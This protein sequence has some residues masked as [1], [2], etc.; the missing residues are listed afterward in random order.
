MEKK[1]VIGIDFGT[2]SGRA[3][4]VDT[5]S[6]DEVG[7]AVF[8]Y[9]H[10]V[11]DRTLPCGRVLP[12][13]F[14]LE[15]PRD[16]LETL[17]NVIPMALKD[18]GVSADEVAAL[19]IDFTACTLLPV[20]EDGTPLC[21]AEKYKSEPHAYVK[22]WKHHASQPE[23]DEIT[24]LAKERGESFLRRYGGKISSE[25]AFPKIL[26][27]LR[28]AP[29]VY[30]DTYRFME[31]ADWLSLVLT[32]VETHSATFAGCKAMWDPH[33]GYPS[34]DFFGALDERMRNIIGTKVSDK[35]AP[36]A[37][38]A[39][40]VTEK[41]S[42]IC[43][44]PVGTALAVPLPD[45]HIAM[46]ALGI[47]TPGEL[48]VILGTSSCQMIHSAEVSDIPGICGYVS[49]SI[50]P[51]YYTYEAGQSC[52]GDTFDRFVKNF[53]PKSYFEEAEREGI[54]IHALLRKKAKD[55]GV[56]KSG[57]LC[58]DWFN[59]NRSIL[60]DDDLSGM[61]LGLTLNT[62]PEQIYRCLIEGTAFGFRRIIDNFT[63]HG[64]AIDSVCA[65]GGIARKDEMMMQIYADVTGR[66]IKIAGTLQAPALAGTIYAA[67]A[68]GIFK[69]VEE[70][71][72]RIAK[73]YYKIYT[74]NEENHKLYGKIYAEYKRLYDY[75]GR[76]ENN[77]MKV[78]SSMK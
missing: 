22:L 17:K 9:P 39:G 68:A 55:E 47:V 4:V 13:K 40:Y 6:G 29:E 52:V 44:L 60:V 75:F 63:E 78:L 27:I 46:P 11:M 28:E 57:L 12:D 36:I 54:N 45:A 26:Q 62:T 5:V 72:A 20:F 74:P 1:Y 35:I 33:E 76:G 65:C 24:A 51:G 3:T 10:A 14:A 43:G 21:F 38:R 67:I 70:A 32:G 61:I 58:L 8:E 48:M 30:E 56:G 69:T 31:A 18:A 37:T 53:V 2:L 25:W 64:V 41:G 77:V 19:G 23:A 16:Y 50:V 15:H 59:G 73:P 34:A 71:S 7:G 66:E 49:D 42:E